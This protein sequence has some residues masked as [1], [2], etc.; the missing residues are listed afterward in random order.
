M[1]VLPYPINKGGGRSIARSAA[2]LLVKAGEIVYAVVGLVGPG[3][4]LRWQDNSF[5]GPDARVGFLVHLP[6][7][8]GPIDLLLYL[9]RR[10]E[11]GINDL[12]IARVVDQF[13]EYVELLQDLDLGDV[14]DFLEMASILVE[15]KSQSVLPK[16]EEVD[17]ENAVIENESPDQLI[18]RLLEYKRIRDAAQILEEMG[19]RWQQRYGRLCDDLP[20]RQLDPGSQPIAD[21]QLWD[22]VSTFGRIIRESSGPPPTEVIYDDTPIHVYMKRIHERLQSEPRVLLIDLIRPK[23]HKSALIGWF[24]AVLEL[25]RHHGAIAE[26]DDNGE[27]V[28]LRGEN[29]GNALQVAEVDNYSAAGIRASNMPTQMR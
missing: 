5:Q 18:E 3:G 11:V 15:I 10:Q 24:L 26:Q 6:A 2:I 19:A 21:L 14:A 29:Y 12:A 22:L 1:I 25:T 20:A 8:R 28:I 7:Y 13:I 16:I 9:V 4:I 17:A 23:V 27:I